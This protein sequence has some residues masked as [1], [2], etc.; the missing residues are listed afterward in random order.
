MSFI[1]KGISENISGSV[2]REMVSPQYRSLP[3]FTSV[4]NGYGP[5]RSC[6]RTFI[7]GEEDRTSF[8]YNPVERV[9][10]LP[11]PGPVFIHSEECERFVDNSFPAGIR[12]LPMYF[13]AFDREGI[14]HSRVRVAE[15]S[16]DEQINSLLAEGTV[17][18]LHIRNAEAGCFIARIERAY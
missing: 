13:E 18:F 16:E 1:V 9:L 4:A 12:G 10:D 7:E 8:T 6:L 11:Q 15:G 3:A 5:C 2:R 17:D 14:M